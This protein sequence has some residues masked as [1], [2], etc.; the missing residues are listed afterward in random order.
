M[1]TDQYVDGTYFEKAKG[2]HASESPWKAANVLKLIRRNALHFETVCDV[3]C[4][5]GEILVELQKALDPDVN[6][7]GFDISPQAITI[8]KQKEQGR[9][10]FHNED[11]L[12]GNSDVFDLILLLDVFEHAQD[13]L[14]FLDAM[15]KRA[16]WFIFHIP[17]DIALR[18][19]SKKSKWMMY[20]RETYGHLHY[21]TAET[22]MATLS[23][24]GYEIVDYF[25]TDDFDVTDKMIPKHIKARL[26]YE[27]RKHLFRIRPHL[28]AAVFEQFNLLVLARGQSGRSASEG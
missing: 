26:V 23:D 17:L 6:F 25:Y 12:T 15:N 10:K 22:A 27:L 8:A 14:G 24:T 3:G 18:G 5:V 1:R 7:S 2:W 16:R 20:M 28:A 21:F 13:Y 9:L 11:F 19:I 4:G